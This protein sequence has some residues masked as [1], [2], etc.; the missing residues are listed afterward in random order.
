M[1]RRGLAALAVAAIAALA[2]C[3]SGAPGQ[4]PQPPTAGQVAAQLGLTR[5]TDCYHQPALYAADSGSAWQRGVKIGIDTFPTTAVRDTWLAAAENLG[6]TPLYEGSTWV[7]YKALD[8]GG[9]A[10]A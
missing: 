9:G 2:G 8:Q 3:G 4:L 1:I 10:C 5:F 7:A 6:V